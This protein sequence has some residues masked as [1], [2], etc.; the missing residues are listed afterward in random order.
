MLLL[1]KLRKKPNAS[2]EKEN[3]IRI[4]QKKD[5]S[6]VT[7]NIIEKID[8]DFNREDLFKTLQDVLPVNIEKKVESEEKEKLEDIRKDK[9]SAIMEEDEALDDDIEK[10]IKEGVDEEGVDEGREDDFDERREEGIDDGDEFG[11]EESKGPQ[12]LKERT[13]I[14]RTGLRKTGMVGT[15]LKANRETQGEKDQ[16]ERLREKFKETT[17]AHVANPYYMNNR[18][19]FV[20]FIKKKNDQHKDG[21]EEEAK[22]VSCDRTATEF[23]L[24]THQ[25]V[26]KDYMSLYTPY[27]GLLIYHGLG[28]GKTCSSIAIAEALKT[29]NEIVVMTPA[30][31]RDNYISELKSCGDEFYKL[32]N[33]WVFIETRDDKG[34]LIPKDGEDGIK[35]AQ[36]EEEK[37]ALTLN[38]PLRYIEKN[39]GAW[40]ALMGKTDKGRSYKELDDTEKVLLTKQINYMIRRRYTF[41][42]YNGIRKSALDALETFDNKV[43]IIDEAHNFVSRIVNKITKKDS[44]SYILYDMLMRANNCK[45]VF[46]TG[47]PIINYPNEIGVLFNMLRGYIKTFNFQVK[48]ISKEKVDEKAIIKLFNTKMVTHD[49]IKYNPSKKI[50]QITR[51]PFG[52][53]SVFKSVNKG[54]KSRKRDVSSKKYMGV[55]YKKNNG[56]C[57][58]PGKQDTCEDGYLCNSNNTCSFISDEQFQ[59]MCTNILENNEIDVVKKEIIEDMALPDTNDEFIENFIDD[60]TKGIK[61]INLFQKRILGLTSYFRSAQEKLMPRY[62]YEKDFHVEELEMSD[63]QFKI[64]E[65]ARQGER[66]LEKK[67]ATKRKKKSNIGNLN[68]ETVSTYRIFSRAFCNF[69]FPQ[70]MERPKPNRDQNLQVAINKEGITEDDLDGISVEEKIEN[71]DGSYTGDDEDELRKLDVDIKDKTYLQRIEDALNEL[72]DDKHIRDGRENEYLNPKA[73]EIHSPKFLKVL[74]NIQDEKNIGLH[75]IYSQFRTLEG[76]GILALVLEANGFAQFKIKKDELNNWVI[77]MKDEDIEKPKFALYT[78]K[79]EKEEKEHIRNIY[80]GMYD[81]VPDSLKDSLFEKI[82]GKKEEGEK[83]KNNNLGKIIKVLMITSSGAEGINLKNTRFVH[84][85]EPYWHPVRIQQVVGRA[86][87]ICSHNELPEELRTVD[88]YLYLMVLSEN[89]KKRQE[90]GGLASK[91]LLENDVSKRDK[92]DGLKVKRPFTSDQTLWEISTIKEDINKQILLAIKSTSIDCKLH[93]GSSNEPYVCLSYKTTSSD[94]SKLDTGDINPD[95]FV[96]DPLFKETSNDAEDMLNEEKIKKKVEKIKLNGKI[97]ALIRNN[98]F[99]SFKQAP[100]G[101]LYLYDDYKVFAKASKKNKNLPL[102][103]P[104]G[105][106]KRNRKGDIYIDK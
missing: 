57:T 18:K 85:I 23:E 77:D 16:I 30:S 97:Y 2:D 50:I 20:D 101:D 89:Q 51:N 8:K 63:Y 61:N 14:K 45:I 41:I 39:S 100:E 75:L 5:E 60:K 12:R 58:Q 24:M 28:A 27:R 46:L 19:I 103:E 96:G 66:D 34:N 76:I 74:Q 35:R 93:K 79:E 68:D 73:L 92:M 53:V 67:N 102:P 32:N 9:L 90:S 95:E 72:K 69:V 54:D 105:K 43:V 7:G 36:E 31:L 56:K 84:I 81:K 44:L 40:V 80:N 1:E 65:E 47:T 64:Y 99:S 106:L 17:V 48:V 22:N 49:Y 15:I 91:E 11:V 10:S 26:V 3:V 42:N 25:K 98:Q 87:R 86:R 62:E 21:L 37:L 71:V 55:Q 83:I 4:I 94:E 104:Y 59:R 82:N 29:T 52:F 33:Q 78:G 88:V 13:G 38:V 70:D 6:G